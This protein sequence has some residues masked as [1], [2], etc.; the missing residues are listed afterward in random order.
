MKLLQSV[1]IILNPIHSPM[2]NY[3][4]IEKRRIFLSDSK[5]YYFSVC[6]AVGK[7]GFDSSRIIFGY[8]NGKPI[9]KTEEYCSGDYKI[10]T[11][12]I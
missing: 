9:Q 5:R 10:V 3:D 7:V 4:K 1:D 8:Y 6:N 2:S 12:Q 11:Y